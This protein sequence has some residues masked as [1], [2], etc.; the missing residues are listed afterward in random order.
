MVGSPTRQ[1][2]IFSPRSASQSRTLVVPLTAGPSSSPVIS[3][4]RLTSSPSWTARNRDAAAT[5]HAIGAL[6][7]S[8]ATTDQ[9]AV[10]KR[11]IERIDRPIAGVS[12][13]YDVGVT[14]KTEIPTLIAVACIKIVDRFGARFLEGQP[15]AGKT[16]AIKRLLQY[17]ERPG[18]HRRNAWTP[19]Q[20]DRE[21]DGVHGRHLAAQEFVNRGLGTGLL[22][23][24]LD[25]DRAV[26]RGRALFLGRQ[27]AGHDHGIGG[28]R[29][30]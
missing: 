30:P 15:V 18:V 5:K 20:V 28:G 19:N 1:T 4:L 25:D 8:G 24:P 22:V 13:R 3:R 14:G 26:K 6:H 23:D 29:G 2:S 12:R 7:V 27:G 11:R 9:D 10:F 17:A 16:Q 21:L